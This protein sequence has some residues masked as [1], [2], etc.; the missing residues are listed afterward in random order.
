M[1][2]AKNRPFLF[3]RFG[4][5][6]QRRAH[7]DVLE[8]FLQTRIVLL[9]IEIL[10]RGKNKCA[11]RPPSSPP[12]PTTLTGTDACEARCSVLP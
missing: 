3:V 6:R 4:D 10:G 5:V 12:I 8:A 11:P 7:F 1:E 2:L 9:R